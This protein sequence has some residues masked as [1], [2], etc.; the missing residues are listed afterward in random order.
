MCV[1]VCV[2]VCAHTHFKKSI[3]HEKGC[4]MSNKAHFYIYNLYIQICLSENLK[5]LSIIFSAL[6]NSTLLKHLA[7]NRD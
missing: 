7:T 6:K 5:N 4:M 2:C 1:C 3:F